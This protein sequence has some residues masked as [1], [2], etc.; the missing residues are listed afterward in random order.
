MGERETLIF[1]T[2]SVRFTLCVTGVGLVESVTLKVSAVLVTICD[3]V[4]ATAPVEAFRVRPVGS[5]PDVRDQ[6][7]GV[8]PPVAASVTE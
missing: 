2:V 1:V 3:G 5:V 4:P 7:Y 8:V 6:V